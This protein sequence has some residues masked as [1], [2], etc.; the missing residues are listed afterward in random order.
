MILDSVGIGKPFFGA[1]FNISKFGLT[2]IGIFFD[3]LFLF[4]HFFL[5]YDKVKQDKKQR[6]MKEN[7]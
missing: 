6:K 4:Q 1:G 5:Y 7:S 3:L 2:V